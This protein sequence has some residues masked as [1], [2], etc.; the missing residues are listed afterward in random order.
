MALVPESVLS[1]SPSLSAGVSADTETAY[2]VFGCELAQVA[3]MLL[4]LPQQAIL[5]AQSILHRFLYRESL[6]KVD[7][8]LGEAERVVHM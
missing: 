3:G 7:A 2:R 5:T 4:K 8:H 1:A 6:T